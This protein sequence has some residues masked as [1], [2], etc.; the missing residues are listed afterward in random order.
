M[1]LTVP[2]LWRTALFYHK[3]SNSFSFLT[4]Y[5]INVKRKPCLSVP[6][7]MLVF[8]ATFLAREDLNQNL[9]CEAKH[10][11]RTLVMNNMWIYLKI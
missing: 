10:L 1:G 8:S 6:N 2:A 9:G 3:I 4:V 11:H 5:A 7:G